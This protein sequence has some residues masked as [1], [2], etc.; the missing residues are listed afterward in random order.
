MAVGRV[1]HRL[2]AVDT[3]DMMAEAEQGVGCCTP[4]APYRACDDDRSPAV[5]WFGMLPVRPAGE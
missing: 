5:H 3:G 1:A 2:L 4:D